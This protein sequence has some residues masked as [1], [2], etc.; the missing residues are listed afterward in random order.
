MKTIDTITEGQKEKIKDYFRFYSKEVVEMF[1]DI[2][3][4]ER[5]AVKGQPFYL[6]YEEI[7]EKTAKLLKEIGATDSLTA[8]AAFQYLLWNGYLSKDKEL[9]YSVS[10]R[11]N[12]LSLAGADIACGKSVCLNNADME[13]QVL[14]A[15]G[16]EAYIIGCRIDP[17][18]ALNLE[19]KPPIERKIDE[20]VKL[21]H[22]VLSKLVEWTPLR[23]IGNHAVT[24]VKAEGRYIV[25]DPTNLCYAN[26]D[27]F[28]NVKVVGSEAKMQLKAWLMLLLHP[29]SY[30]TFEKIALE[31][32]LLGD[33]EELNTFKVKQVF[34]N[35]IYLCKKNNFLLD[36]FHDDIVPAIEEVH[37][38]LT[39]SNIRK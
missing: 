33:K 36:D 28:M 5:E 9:L 38:T 15:M 32:F 26:F 25:S 31:S 27:D 11:K 30:E 8:S 6:P 7:I 17:T 10:Y 20:H 34:E 37:R 12:N 19:Y 2:L 1:G 3:K 13:A 23:K 39:K 24:L 21:S 29:M 14:R 18:T 22:R 35:G 16:K 4:E